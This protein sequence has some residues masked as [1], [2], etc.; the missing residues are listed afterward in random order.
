[1]SIVLHFVAIPS[2]N[3]VLYDIPSILRNYPKVNEVYSVQ[4]E[5]L[6]LQEY[7]QLF[8]VLKYPIHDV[9]NA[10]RLS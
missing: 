3:Q 8:A 2:T 4:E 5:N 6:F 9:D 1:M 10:K 7:W